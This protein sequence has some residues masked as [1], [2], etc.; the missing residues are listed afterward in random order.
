MFTG[1][2]PWDHF[3]H[4]RGSL[5][6]SPSLKTLAEV[7]LGEGYRTASLSAN[8]WVSDATGL[9]RGFETALRGESGAWLG[10]GDP[11]REV[12]SGATPGDPDEIS[13][14]TSPRRRG[15]LLALS[16]LVV[17]RYPW[18][19]DLTRR[20]V[21]GVEAGSHTHLPHRCEWIEPSF[22]QIVDGLG[23]TQPFFCFVNLLDAHEPFLLDSTV[24]TGVRDWWRY[25]ASGQ[26]PIFY[27]GGRR[28][29]PSESTLTSMHRRYVQAILGLDRRLE[30]LLGVLR[31]ADRLDDTLV[32]VASDHGQAFG[33]AGQMFHQGLPY[34]EMVRVP[35]MIRP[36]GGLPSQRVVPTWTSITDL[37]RQIL[38][39]VGLD[40]G[41]N[42]P[43]S[44]FASAPG[45][46]V[47]LPVARACSDGLLRASRLQFVLSKDE[48]AA[49]DKASAVA[50]VGDT[51]VLKMEGGPDFIHFDA[52]FGPHYSTG[53]E[54]RPRGV[55][56][57]V[58]ASLD[59]VL[60]MLSHG[61][62]AMWGSPEQQESAVGRHLE[63]WGY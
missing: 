22:K 17:D 58:Y 31:K 9:A 46:D 25:Y 37:P 47:G 51:G 55:P 44:K 43:N 52:T 6:L 28:P 57:A 1:L 45:S 49:V 38:Q 12:G 60:T 40:G 63:S 14:A 19:L 34:P 5:R 61:R 54:E 33:E 2:D 41:L 32:V 8:E 21:R 11:T 50:Y 15:N 3:C 62:R 13:F 35:V 4:A 18:L 56:D 42:L 23:T 39:E 48:Y 36:P 30:M 53:F 7:F 16:G 24:S 59:K 10:H 20:V 27:R 29:L 26:N